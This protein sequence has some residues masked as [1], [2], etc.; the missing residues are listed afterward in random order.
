VRIENMDKKTIIISAINFS[1]GGPLTIYKECLKYLEENFLEEYRIIALV[2]DRNL[3]SEYESKIEFIEFKDSKKSYLKR[4][5]YEYFYFKKLSEKWK[6]YLW[7]SLHDMTPNVK[8]DKRV[9]YCHN[10]IIFYNVKKEDIISEFKMFMFSK[11]YKYVYRINIRKND[12]VVVQQDWIRKRFKELFKIK[13]VIV[14]HPN[15]VIDDLD[16]EKTGRNNIKIA[17]NSFLYPAFPRIFKNFEV[18]CEA[19]KIL[20]KKNVTDFT[21]YLTVDGSENLYSKKLFEKYK[22]L[23]NIKFLGLLERK[24][25]MKYYK[26]SENI[27]FPSKLET[28][29]LPI[30]EAKIFGKNI[31]LADLEYA[32]ET[33]GNYGNVIF[34]EPDDAKKL[35]EKMEILINGENVKF[36]GNLEKNIE[37]PFCRNWKELFEIL[38]SD[39]K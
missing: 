14:A 7:L 4:M 25:L 9:V 17:K 38:L 31:L 20:D 6:P 23:K 15:V 19:V 22:D 39:N 24:E 18:I 34:F 1:E 11:F 32:H 5:Y 21:V 16:L 29:G 35:A 12:F 3:F 37:K 8:A 28:W 2:H 27:I 36:D 10:G 26:S 30:T 33:L 13:N